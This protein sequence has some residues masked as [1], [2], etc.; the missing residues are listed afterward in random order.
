[1][2]NL[3][4]FVHLTKFN[5]VGNYMSCQTRELMLEAQEKQMARKKKLIYFNL[6]HTRR[7]SLSGCQSTVAKILSEHLS[8]T[9]YCFVKPDLSRSGRQ[10]FSSVLQKI[11]QQLD[12]DNSELWGTVQY[13]QIQ[14]F[15]C[16]ILIS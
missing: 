6:E 7:T 12:K 15:R 5:V 9:D 13:L 8:H 10:M 14:I 3:T 2:I 1:M 4:N 16:L 11:I